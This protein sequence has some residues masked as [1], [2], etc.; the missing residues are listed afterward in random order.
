MPRMLLLV[1]ASVLAWPAFSRAQTAGSA[2]QSTE[3]F[4]VGTFLIGNAPTVGIVLR[5][6]LVIDL[7]QANA[8]MEKSRSYPRRPM[9]ADMVALIG[10]YDA[11]LKGRIYAI[12][13]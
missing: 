10:D 9:P 4:K 3:P 5:D 8:A 6:S 2:S 7:A 13:N 12:V 1:V 11:G